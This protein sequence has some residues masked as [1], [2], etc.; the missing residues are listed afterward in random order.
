MDGLYN[1]ATLVKD[2]VRNNLGNSLSQMSAQQW[3]RLITAIC[4]YLLVRPY[5][6]SLA[7]KVQMKQMEKEEARAEAEA[8]EQRA[9][10]SPNEFRGQQI[11]GVPEDT[12]DEEDGEP[13]AP[14]Q[15]GK[16]ARRRQRQVVRKIL[17]DHEQ[18]LADQ[19]GDDEDKDIEEFLVD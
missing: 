1:M 10:M 19:A 6:V 18:K 9:K 12:D 4:A 2:R 3:I 17:E 11:A 7:G 16:K 8:A 15:W 14:A 13:A 5:L